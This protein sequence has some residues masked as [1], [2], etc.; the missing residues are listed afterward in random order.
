MQLP[1]VTPA[2]VQRMAR[3]MDALSL[4]GMAELHQRQ[5]NRFG[6]E[7]H[8]F[9]SAS[10]SIATR[11]VGAG[12]WNRVRGLTEAD[13]GRVGEIQALYRSHSLRGNVDLTPVAIT[14]RLGQ[15]L[16]AAGFYLAGVSTVLYGLSGHDR[17]QDIH[18]DFE[19]R[20]VGPDQAADVAQLWAQG[21]E[22]PLDEAGL[23]ARDIRQAWFAVPENRRYIG[24]VEGQPAAM[25]ALYTKDRI[26]FL[27][28]GAT[29]PAYRRRGIHSALARLRMADAGASGCELVIGHTGF[30]GTSQNNEERN[31][32]RIAFLIVNFEME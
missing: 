24:Y 15:A 32:L 8:A 26:G 17:P 9:G 21:F 7:M 14:P 12:W 22:I 4:A 6:V 3:V 31:G 25:A 2:L 16:V 28:V 23:T 11:A 27:N 19:I 30:G 1:V 29:L 10:A 18:G 13:A 20:E 5:G